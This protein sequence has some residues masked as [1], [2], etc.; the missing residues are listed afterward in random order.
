MSA[1]GP[2]RPDLKIAGPARPPEAIHE[3]AQDLWETPKKRGFT[4]DDVTHLD[5]QI[6]HHG[7]H[8]QRDAGP[9]VLFQ[10]GEEPTIGQVPQDLPADDLPG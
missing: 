4:I 5:R 9:G 8:D 10:I 2:A 6:G 7:N 1:T 3:K